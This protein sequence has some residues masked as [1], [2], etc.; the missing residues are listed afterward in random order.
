MT[1]QTMQTQS[2]PTMA[3]MMTGTTIMRILDQK[4][5][6]RMVIWVPPWGELIIYII[7]RPSAGILNCS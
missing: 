4:R 1:S 6:F 3:V 7:A 5:R 2:R